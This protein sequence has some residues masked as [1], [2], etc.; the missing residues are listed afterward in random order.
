MSLTALMIYVM[1]IFLFHAV[2]NSSHCTV[3]SL[4]QQHQKIILHKSK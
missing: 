3:A 2:K 4:Y 1:T